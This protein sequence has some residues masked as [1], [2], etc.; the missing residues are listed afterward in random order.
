MLAAEMR[1]RGFVRSLMAAWRDDENSL[2][3]IAVKFGAPI[4]LQWS[5]AETAQGFVRCLSWLRV[6]IHP[7]PSLTVCV[8]YRRAHRA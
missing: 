2:K 3:R 1:Q 8:G 5:A 7:V 6:R 4:F